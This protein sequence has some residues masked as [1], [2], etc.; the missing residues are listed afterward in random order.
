MRQLR[1]R[2]V[3]IGGGGA[4]LSK[5]FGIADASGIGRV[6]S[7]VVPDGVMPDGAPRGGLHCPQAT[8]FR[9]ARRRFAGQVV[10]R[11]RAIAA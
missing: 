5:P 10:A 11:G 4:S 1:I 9:S 3:F 8:R 2:A 7:V 6:D